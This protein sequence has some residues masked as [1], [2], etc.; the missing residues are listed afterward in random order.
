MSWL[1]E[2]WFGSKESLEQVREEIHEH[3]H[4]E[5][6]LGVSGIDHPEQS[7]NRIPSKEL[8]LALHGP[9][10]NNLDEQEVELLHFIH[11]ELPPVVRDEVGIIPFFTQVTQEGYLVLTYIRNATNRSVLLQRLPLSL[12]TPEGE[13]VARKTFEM[14]TFGPIGDESS[15]LCEFLFRWSE[16]DKIPEKEVPLTLEYRKPD[17]KA[18]E[19]GIAGGELTEAEQQK[20]REQAAAFPVEEG[21][22]DLQVLDI[23]EGSNNGLKVVVLFRNG[24]NKRLEFTDVPI[25]VRDQA[26]DA[27]ARVQYTLENMKVNPMGQRIWSFE[28]PVAS[29]KKE[30]VKAADCTVYIPQAKQQHNEKKAASEA[31]QPKGYLQ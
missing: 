9:W 8:F 10:E 2:N 28:I 17:K 11:D 27:V 12:V 13:V 1:L 25:I 14:L 30:G 31:T 5:I 22:V 21:K 3:L 7:S 24:L 19:P 29:I 16:F 20:Y 26:G 4:K 15:R 6:Y 23:T 18:N